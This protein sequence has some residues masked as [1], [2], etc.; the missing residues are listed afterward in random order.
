[1][2]INPMPSEVLPKQQIVFALPQVGNGVKIS[3]VLIGFLFTN[4]PF[5]NETKKFRNYV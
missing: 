3:E 5:N 1:M 4:F 2:S